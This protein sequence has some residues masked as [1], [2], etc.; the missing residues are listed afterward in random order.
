MDKRQ[1]IIEA[2]IQ[3]FTQN[4]FHATSTTSITKKAKVGTG[5]LFTY[6]SNKDEMINTIYLE[7]KERFALTLKQ[8]IDTSETA[9]D[10]FK[11]LWI[12]AIKWGVDNYKDYTFT[13]QYS[14]S[15]YINN[16]TKEESIGGF[17][18]MF[19]ILDNAINQK[20]VKEIPA[21]L[22]YNMIGGNLHAIITYIYTTDQDINTISENTF[23]YVWEGIRK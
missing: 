5:T 13:H 6:F 4:G 2:A 15:P 21:D 10:Q 22:F 9:Y 19:A 16:L 18:F 1:Q 7:I 3:L 8:Q 20:V 23:K 14:S 11:S 17:S 12:N